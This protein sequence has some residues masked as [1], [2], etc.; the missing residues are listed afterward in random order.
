MNDNTYNQKRYNIRKNIYRLK[1]GIEHFFNYPMLNF[2]WVF[3]IIGIVFLIKG[4]Q[5]LLTA[6]EIP[7]ILMPIFNFCVMFLIVFL[8]IVIIIGILQGIGNLIAKKDEADII[9]VFDKKDI[10]KSCP[11]L[12]QKKTFKNGITIREFY[13]KIPMEK[14]KERKDTLADVFNVHFVG[15]I[16]YGGKS[17]GNKI[18]IKTAKGRKAK[19]RG[20]LYDDRF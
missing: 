3:I 11:I 10:E 19:D 16:E 9:L 20:I 18:L 6:F 13:S 15:E 14:W 2:I 7:Q 1:L 4:E 17:N 12:I 5:K 8:P